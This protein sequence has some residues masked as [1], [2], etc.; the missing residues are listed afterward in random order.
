MPIPF[1]GCVESPELRYRAW[2]ASLGVAD[3]DEVV[4]EQPAVAFG[5]VHF[6]ARGEDGARYRAGVTPSGIVSAAARTGEDWYGLL[7]ATADPMQIAGAV[8]WLQTPVGGQAQLLLPT[9][10]IA[11]DP[12]RWVQ[13]AAPTLV[14]GAREIT[15]QAWLIVDGGEPERWEIHAEP[16]RA[17]VTRSPLG[18]AP[19]G[20]IDRARTVLMA[21]SSA[22]KQW[23]LAELAGRVEGVD[24]LVAYLVDPAE[25]VALRVLATRSLRVTGSQTALDALGRA[26]QAE[27]SPDVRRAAAQAL[28]T[29]PGGEVPLETASRTEQDTA[30]RMEVVH[31]LR[32]RGAAEALARIAR[33]DADAAVRALAALGPAR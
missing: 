14:R 9:T 15:F 3:Q 27:T 17:T 5:G 10:P 25:D 30:V 31:A 33:E 19:A 13:V 23:A 1:A 21:G 8:V 24:V 20:A 11:V 12:A 4:H 29:L 32:A 7:S 26:L 18:A 28:G 2:L 16:G 22:Q 6:F